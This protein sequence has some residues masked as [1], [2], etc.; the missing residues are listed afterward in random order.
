MAALVAAGWVLRVQVGCGSDGSAA[1]GC[2]G[3]S[4]TTVAT[5]PTVVPYVYT[6]CQKLLQLELCVCGCAEACGRCYMPA[7]MA[8]EAAG[9]VQVQGA[10]AH[11]GARRAQA[12]AAAATQ[13]RW[14][15]Q[16]LHDCCCLMLH[17]SLVHG[18]YRDPLAYDGHPHQDTGDLQRSSTLT[19]E[20]DRNEG[21]RYDM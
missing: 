6:C 10:C 17:A 19:V 1:E 7:A 3:C 21:L 16:A 5:P 18:S 15:R 2:L 9:A 4:V 11:T 13:Q 14:L 8:R 12:G 20:V